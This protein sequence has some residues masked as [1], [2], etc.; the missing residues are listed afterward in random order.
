MNIPLPSLRE[1]K[2][3]IGALVQY[4]IESLNEEY[5]R[6]VRGAA[7]E[8]LEHLARY[9]WPGN[10][11][12]LRNSVERLMMLEQANLLSPEYLS[13]ELKLGGPAQGD[14][15]SLSV[16]S[17]S[18]GEHLTLPATGISLEDLEKFVIQLALRKSGGN[19][20][21]AARFLKT[22]RDTLRYRMKKYD[23][24]EPPGEGGADGCTSIDQQRV[25]KTG[26]RHV[27]Q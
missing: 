10:V 25:S 2:E 5:G 20:A 15:S 18:S 12:E 17:D 23:L 4:F 27:Q 21:K 26:S 6:S 13:P 11:R 22:T 1:R 16:R 19:Q 3:D 9:D 14:G 8:T 7:P 24:P